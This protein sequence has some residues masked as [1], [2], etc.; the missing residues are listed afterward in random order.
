MDYQQDLADAWLDHFRTH[1]VK[2]SFDAEHGIIMFEMRLDKCKISTAKVIIILR[3]SFFTVFTVLPLQCEEQHRS[4]L[5]ILLNRINYTIALGDFE[6]NADNGEIRFRYS[7][8]TKEYIP[9]DEMMVR[10]IAFGL[11]KI[12]EWADPVTAILFGL[13]TADKAFALATGKQPKS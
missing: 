12:Q 7:V 4:E 11:H 1:G 5:A 8:D 6:M 3:E 2:Y 10:S 9:G 13:T